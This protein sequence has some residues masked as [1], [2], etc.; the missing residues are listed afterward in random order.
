MDR[1]L[2]GGGEVRERFLMRA[3]CAC[4]ESREPREKALL[5]VGREV[6]AQ[7]RVDE[8]IDLS[9]ARAGRL[10][11]RNDR[12]GDRDDERALFRGQRARRPGRRRWSLPVSASREHR[13]DRRCGEGAAEQ[14]G[15]PA[16]RFATSDVGGD[17]RPPWRRGQGMGWDPTCGARHRLS[18]EEL[19]LVR[20]ETRRHF[21][22]PMR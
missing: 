14:H 17:V 16:Q 2:L 15:G 20:R 3:A 12:P 8:S 5:V 22:V 9:G 18:S 7:H 1:R 13:G 4:V 11:F 6:I 21:G 19:W 10:R